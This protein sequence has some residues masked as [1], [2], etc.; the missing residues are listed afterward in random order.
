MAAWAALMED[1]PQCFDPKERATTRA[2][3]E[4]LEEN[5]ALAVKAPRARLYAVAA[6]TLGR[7]AK[8]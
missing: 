8:R 7:M 6:I 5:A 2:M 3:A 1:A 4:G